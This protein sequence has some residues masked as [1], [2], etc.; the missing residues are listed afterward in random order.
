MSRAGE[1]RNGRVGRSREEQERSEAAVRGIFSLPGGQISRMVILV[2]V[3]RRETSRCWGEELSQ[4]SFL[5][6]EPHVPA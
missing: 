2:L 5:R 6:F 1:A 4:A 3:R